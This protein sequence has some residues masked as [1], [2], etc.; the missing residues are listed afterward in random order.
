MT[1]S[2]SGLAN[3]LWNEKYGK[4]VPFE[5]IFTVE[6]SKDKVYKIDAYQSTAIKIDRATQLEILNL[7]EFNEEVVR[8]SD[9]R[10]W[11]SFNAI[12]KFKLTY[13]RIDYFGE[14]IFRLGKNNHTTYFD[15][16][17]TRKVHFVAVDFNLEVNY[18]EFLFE[19]E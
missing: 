15:K 14:V 4:D 11:E 13:N 7:D 18:E 6:L 1:I 8:V 9:S 17:C 16:N 3:V 12:L 19:I 10:Q 5:A 2:W